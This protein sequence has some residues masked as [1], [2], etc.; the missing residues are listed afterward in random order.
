MT[1]DEKCYP[2]QLKGRERRALPISFPH[3]FAFVLNPFSVQATLPLELAPDVMLDK[4][5]PAEREAIQALLDELGDLAKWGMLFRFEPIPW[6]VRESPAWDRKLAPRETFWVIRG[7]NSKLV[8][9]LC[10]V[11]QL[12]DCELE[13][14][15]IFP[16]SDNASPRVVNQSSFFYYPEVRNN[17]NPQPL[18]MDDL[19]SVHPL[20]LRLAEFEA[21]KDSDKARGSIVRIFDNFVKTSAGKRHGDLALLGHFALIEGLI[22]HNARGR[23]DTITH[24]LMTKMPLLMRRFRRPLSLRDCVDIDDAGEAWRLFY[25][26]RSRIAHGEGGFAPELD[27]PLRGADSVFLFIR[28]ALKRLLVLALDDPDFIFDL[29]AC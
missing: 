26:L 14:A 4:A 29:R 28:E 1:G 7:G 10:D 9:R 18:G 3:D 6:E 11:S 20:L 24:Q 21:V 5:L 15:A 22:T 17:G 13:L 27:S 12:C 2:V 25:K 23:G 8:E 19:R 16:P